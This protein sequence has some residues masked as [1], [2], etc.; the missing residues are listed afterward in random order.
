MR[1]AIICLT[2]LCFF[3]TSTSAIWYASKLTSRDEYLWNMHK[4]MLH[5]FSPLWWRVWPRS[6]PFN[7]ICPWISNLDEFVAINFSYLKI[8]CNCVNLY[9]RR[10]VKSWQL[11]GTNESKPAKL[12]MHVPEQCHLMRCEHRTQKD[13]QHQE[14]NLLVWNTTTATTIFH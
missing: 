2:Q 9:R 4:L 14:E 10:I 5:S 7:F 13:F 12:S 6:I 11:A 1:K 8:L 3:L